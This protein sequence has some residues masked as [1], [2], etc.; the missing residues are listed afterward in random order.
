[1]VFSSSSFIKLTG[2]NM[3]YDQKGFN[4][5][6]DYETCNKNVTPGLKKFPFYCVKNKIPLW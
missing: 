2:R 1:M 3:M 4:Y 5:N 6:T